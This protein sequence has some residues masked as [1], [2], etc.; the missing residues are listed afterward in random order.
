MKDLSKIIK[1]NQ[2]IKINDYNGDKIN[3]L[4]NDIKGLE[5]RAAEINENKEFL[6]FNIIYDMNS[7]NDEENRFIQTMTDL[8]NFGSLLNNKDGINPLSS[9]EVEITNIRDYLFL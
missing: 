3:R 6:L 1:D 7:V 8:K 2:N 5:Q 4:K 9:N